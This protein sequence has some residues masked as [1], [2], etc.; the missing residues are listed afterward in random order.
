MR[1]LLRNTCLGLA[2]LHPDTI[3]VGQAHCSVLESLGIRR[4]LVLVSV[5]YI[6]NQGAN[7]VVE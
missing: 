2:P 5:F 1:K 4:T 7:Y 6:W 3:L